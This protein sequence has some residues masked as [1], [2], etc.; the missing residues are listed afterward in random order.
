MSDDI[1]ALYPG[2][3]Q[4]GDVRVQQENRQRIQDTQ[5]AR[6]SGVGE[7]ADP[8]YITSME[9]FDSMTHEEMY[10]KANTIRPA[11]IGQLAA[12]WGNETNAVSMAFAKFNASLGNAIGGGW[13]GAA[14]DNATAGVGTFLSSASNV[15]QVMNAVHLRLRAVEFGS[16]EVVSRMPP[17]VPAVPGVDLFVPG[18]G[19]AAEAA[20]EEAR[21]EAVRV[22]NGA[23]VPT[24]QTAGEGVPAF[25]AAHDPTSGGLGDGD[26][27]RGTDSGG[28]GE[29]DSGRER[30]LAADPAL[31]GD[32][33]DATRT[34]SAAAE[35]GP[36]GADR[37]RPVVQNDTGTGAG[38]GS[39]AGTSATGTGSGAGPAGLGT[40]PA[41]IGGTGSAATGS[42]SR[43][44]ADRSA[45]SGARGLGGTAG[46]GSDAGAGTEGQRPVVGGPPVTPGTSPVAGT[47]ARGA[48]PGA[49]GMGGMGHAGTRAAGEDDE[50]HRTPGYLV[51]VDN[52]NE[53]IGDL[54]RVA[55]PVLGA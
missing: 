15:G 25:A 16:A 47:G 28:G 55:P 34:E 23:Y 48:G 31:D 20:R 30:G 3:G 49:A 29:T 22:M 51:N 46:T 39:G 1:G 44:G 37:S 14:A 52:G 24:Y 54:P 18:A 10:A 38:P 35:T 26:A 45:S 19:K 7:G 33:S 5:S 40:A 2:I 50:E 21:L 36:S 42:G 6:E 32:T 17:P 8:S 12:S 27:G 9:F 43:S 53:L 11:D 41:G 13:R 4:S